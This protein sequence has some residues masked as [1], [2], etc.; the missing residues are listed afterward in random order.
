MRLIDA[1][2]APIFLDTTACEQIK[3]MQTIDAAVVTRCVDCIYANKSDSV[4]Y[5]SYWSNYTQSCGYCS[6]GVKIRYVLPTL[7][8]ASISEKLLSITRDLILEILP[9]IPKW[10]FATERNSVQFEWEK[11]NGDYLE[12]E[13]YSKDNIGMLRIIDN[14]EIERKVQLKELKHEIELF[15]GKEYL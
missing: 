12:F 10:V 5:C 13:V 6:S 2:M 8:K 4:L 1:D 9:Y 14:Q 15:L 11:V 3:F 7:S